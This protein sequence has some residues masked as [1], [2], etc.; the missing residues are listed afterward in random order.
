MK[1][2]YRLYLKTDEDKD[3]SRC[4]SV[5]TPILENVRIG[6]TIAILNEDDDIG[7]SD[8]YTVVSRTFYEEV[9]TILVEIVAEKDKL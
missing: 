8:Y 1:Y 9:N 5:C 3:G 7:S 2:D 4:R 6:D